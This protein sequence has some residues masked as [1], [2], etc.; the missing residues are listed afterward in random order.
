MIECQLIVLFTKFFVL[1]P[2]YVYRVPRQFWV[3]IEMFHD[4]LTYSATGRASLKGTVVK[5]K[6]LRI[7]GWCCKKYTICFSFSCHLSHVSERGSMAF[8]AGRDLLWIGAIKSSPHGHHLIHST[9][10]TIKG[11]LN[12]A[13][14]S[15]NEKQ[16]EGKLK[17]LM[18]KPGVTKGLDSCHI[19]R[20]D[21]VFHLLK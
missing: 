5:P 21:C 17:R 4:Y 1:K 7:S 8:S 18:C 13:L 19:M 20:L 15:L 12:A 11:L 3:D 10:A 9:H 14:L 6:T 2:A 16:L